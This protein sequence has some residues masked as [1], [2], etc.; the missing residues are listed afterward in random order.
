MSTF[1]RICVSLIL[2]FV[3][4]APIVLQFQ[5]VQMFTH[6]NSSNLGHIKV[7]PFCVYGSSAVYPEVIKT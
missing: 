3:L 6:E 7:R 1:F 2:G 5:M 4:S